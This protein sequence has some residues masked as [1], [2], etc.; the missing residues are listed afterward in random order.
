M[1]P[2]QKDLAIEMP[3]GPQLVDYF[4]YETFSLHQVQKQGYNRGPSELWGS[5]RAHGCLPTCPPVFSY[6]EILRL[7]NCAHTKKCQGHQYL[8]RVNLK[9]SS[10]GY[11]LFMGMS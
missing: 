9:V 1:D 5:G 2:I 7:L 3:R 10:K 6:L 11:Q 4:A 8:H